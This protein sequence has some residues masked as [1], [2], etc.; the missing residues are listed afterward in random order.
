MLRLVA[1]A[2]LLMLLSWNGTL[3]SHTLECEAYQEC[4]RNCHCC[5]S[6]GL[7]PPG[8]PD[9]VQIPCP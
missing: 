8:C 7:A 4:T 6:C 3:S 9:V 2:A 5:E 1:L